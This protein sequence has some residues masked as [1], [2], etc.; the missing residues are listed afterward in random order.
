MVNA[1]LCKNLAFVDDVSEPD[2]QVLFTDL[3]TVKRSKLLS[4]F[5]VFLLF[6]AFFS[7][8]ASVANWRRV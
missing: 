7:F 4:S 3:E 6:S 2:S 1:V 5:S 8:I